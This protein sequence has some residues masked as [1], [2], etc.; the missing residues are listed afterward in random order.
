MIEFE[1]C[2]AIACINPIIYTE[3]HRTLAQTWFTASQRA[4]W[5]F[6]LPIS[7]RYWNVR[8]GNPSRV[9]KQRLCRST[10]GRNVTWRT[11]SASD[12][13]NPGRANC[14]ITK[15]KLTALF[16]AT[17]ARRWTWWNLAVW[18]DSGTSERSIRGCSRV[19]KCAVIKGCLR[20]A[21]LERKKSAPHYNM[22]D[23]LAR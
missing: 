5:F 17:D 13:P 9:W 1:A 3:R 2:I 11:R 15:R 10:A 14:V 16:F 8:P 7:L 19:M 12:S 23:E 4:L 22:T 6:F 20:S 18:V 21:L